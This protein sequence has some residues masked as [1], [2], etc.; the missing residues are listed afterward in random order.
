MASNQKGESC[1]IPTNQSVGKRFKNLSDLGGNE[2]NVK[3]IGNAICGS[4]RLV[5]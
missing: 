4:S 1:P 2:M 3:A 5:S